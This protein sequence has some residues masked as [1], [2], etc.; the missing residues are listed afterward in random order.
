MPQARGY[1][2]RRLLWPHAPRAGSQGRPALHVPCSL[3][4]H[5]HAQ[6]CTRDVAQQGALPAPRPHP[7]AAR[8]RRCAR[9]G[10]PCPCL[11]ML[12][13]RHRRA[14]SI[15]CAPLAA[16]R[17]LTAGSRTHAAA[18]NSSRAPATSARCPASVA[19]PSGRHACCATL[20][21]GASRAT[22]APPIPPGFAGL[23]APGRPPPARAWP[24]AA[25]PLSDAA[26]SVEAD[27]RR[28]CHAI[29]ARP[30]GVVETRAR[31]AP[32]TSYVP[33]RATSI[34][35]RRVV[36]HHTLTFGNVTRGPLRS[37]H[38]QGATH[39]NFPFGKPRGRAIPVTRL[40]LASWPATCYYIHVSGD[41]PL[42]TSLFWR[43][44]PWPQHSI[45][46]SAAVSRA[47]VR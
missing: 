43:W 35:M 16:G 39:R 8:Q 1:L 44:P 12:R 30:P 42:D 23:A 7:C 5:V 19:G 21:H 26:R 31:A 28:G 40:F 41:E 25:N 6:R 2:A 38:L 4:L 36:I 17:S 29:S 47:S 33:C 13:A 27:Q 24:R 22:P 11:H 3:A 14:R 45:A 34:E 20:R 37:C 46:W 15:R 32:P 18:R 10:E 9:G